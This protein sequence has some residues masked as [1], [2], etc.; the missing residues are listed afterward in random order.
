MASLLAPYGNRGALSV[1]QNLDAK[2]EDVLRQA[3]AGDGVGMTFGGLSWTSISF[4]PVPIQRAAAPWI[5][6]H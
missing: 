2:L 1:A 3:A 4:L 6:S 5:T